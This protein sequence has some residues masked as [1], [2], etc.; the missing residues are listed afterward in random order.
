LGLDDRPG[1]GLRPDGLPDIAWHEVPAGTFAMGGDRKVE[2][3]AWAGAVI[4]LP[5]P[6]WLARYPVTCAQFRPFVEAG[7]YRERRYWTEAGWR[8]KQER[9]QPIYWKDPRWQFDNHPV[10]GIT[11]FEAFAYTRWL[12]EQCQRQ[13]AL[14]PPA[15]ADLARRDDPGMLV[16]LPTEA[17]W[18]KAARYPDGRAYPWSGE[19]CPGYANVRE[20]LGDGTEEP[21]NLGRTTAVGMYARGISALGIHDLAGNV[22]DW[23]L[24]LGEERYR[25]PEETDPERDGPR[26]TRGGAWLRGINVARCAYRE[27]VEP[28]AVYDDQGFRLCAAAPS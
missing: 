26:V 1:V 4:D 8:W 14:L 13:P 10:V 11:F 21:C 24:S 25:H 20:Q 28:D 27:P 15:L 22:F 17:E 16:R 19:Y 18:E 6:F 7:G 12:D 2:N 3:R 5:A 9:A 23:C